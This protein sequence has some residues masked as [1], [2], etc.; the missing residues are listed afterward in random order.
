[1]APAKAKNARKKPKPNKAGKIRVGK[2]GDT[3]TPAYQRLINDPCNAP[4]VR[5]YPGEMGVIQRFT[6]DLTLN[7]TAGYTSGVL[8]VVPAGNNYATAGAAA[9]TTALTPN[10]GP[11]GGQTY[12]VGAAKKA[13]CLA[14]CVTAI[15]SAVSMSNITGEIAAGNVSA[16]TNLSGATVDGVF[17]LLPARSVLAKR[18]YDVKFMPA[19]NDGDYNLINGA[20]GFSVAA[21]AGSNAVVI[22][23]R[24]YAPGTAISFRVTVVV[25]WTP[26]PAN[27]LA[28]SNMDNNVPYGVAQQAAGALSLA[29]P[30]WWHTLSESFN[31]AASLISGYAA[32]VIGKAAVAAL[33]QGVRAAPL[34]LA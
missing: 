19:S 12:L 20:N 21:P 33:R 27:G 6:T 14:A 26:L 2:T 22:A 13:R 9:S 5:P 3:L 25:E 31:N 10:S 8:Y 29:H 24:G 28:A 7:T 11:L 18:P 4:Y 17:Q 16:D 34:L 30:H 32:P 15:P 23:W 1:M